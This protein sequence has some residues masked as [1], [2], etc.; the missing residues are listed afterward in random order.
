MEEIV[1]KLVDFVEKKLEQIGIDL[2]IEDLDCIRDTLDIV[3]DGH[4]KE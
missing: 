3:L 4:D 2:S 1:D